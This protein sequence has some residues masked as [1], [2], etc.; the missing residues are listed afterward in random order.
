MECIIRF[1][2]IWSK[3]FFVPL[4]FCFYQVSEIEENL[5]QQ[6]IKEKLYHKNISVEICINIKISQNMTD[7]PSSEPHPIVGENGK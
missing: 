1:S 7:F 5:N 2:P 3:T 6:N 4:V